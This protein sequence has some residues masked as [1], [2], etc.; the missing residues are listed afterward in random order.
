MET[1]IP[2]EGPRLS[3]SRS[4]CLFCGSRRGT[5][6]AY[7]EAAT[8]LGRAVAERSI[9][10]VYGGGRVG[11]MGVAADAALDAGGSVVGVIPQFLIDREVGHPGLGEQI[12]VDTMHARKERMFRLSD[13][14]VSLP[15]GLGTFDET[16][17]IVTWRQLGHHAK[18]VFL[19]DIG[20]YWSSFTNLVE[21]AIGHGFAGPE[22]RG[23]FRTI[24]S[25]DALMAAF[26]AAVPAR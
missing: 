2:T 10:L 23:L 7:R 11:L 8:E 24:E 4:L 18:P 21:H 17:E 6:P 3:D 20:G 19:L 1:A 12:V 16:I 13:A 14:F 25:V 22:V 26:D 9:R 15:G 5:L